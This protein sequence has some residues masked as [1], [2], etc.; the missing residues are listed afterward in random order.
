M[1]VS[2]M[3]WMAFVAALVLVCGAGCGGG[4]STVSGPKGEELDLIGPGNVS[5]EQGGEA[6]ITVKIK[7]KGFDDDVNL[8]FSPPP[9]GVKIEESSTKIQKGGTEAT[10]LLKAD[11][12]AK[13]E[14]VKMKVSATSGSMRA[15]PVDFAVNVKE[16]KK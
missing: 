3:K 11:E 8:E 12:K 5:I 2:P 7:K 13:V 15:G 16:K 4:K 6:K 10:F 14:V 1:E 9:E